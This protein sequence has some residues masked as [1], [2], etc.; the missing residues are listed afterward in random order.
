MTVMELNREQLTELKQSYYCNEVRE[1][2]GVSYGEL[3]AID[4]LVSDEEVFEY[5]DG[6]VFV[7]DDFWCSASLPQTVSN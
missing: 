3:A 6:Y 1:G 7:E 4:E 5:F 2:E